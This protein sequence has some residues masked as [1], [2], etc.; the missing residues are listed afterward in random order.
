MLHLNVLG[1]VKVVRSVLPA[2]RHQRS[3][4]LCFIGSMAG[5]AGVYGLSAYS[6]TKF[7]LRGLAESL[8]MEIEHDGISVVLA[9]PP[10]TE[11]PLLE[12]ENETKPLITKLLSEDA[13]L[14]SPE[15]VADGILKGCA[16]R[17]F[18]V[19]FGIDGFM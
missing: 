18:V 11:T 10:D 6:P 12:R 3:G 9:S 15:S 17:R 16:K 8:R 13:G 2:M 7:A 1:V 14:W 5:Q 19:G 4:V